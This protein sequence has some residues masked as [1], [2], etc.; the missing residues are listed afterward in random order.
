M[1]LLLHPTTAQELERFLE[2]PAHALGVFGEIGAGKSAVADRIASE[3]LKADVTIDHPAVRRLSGDDGIEAVRAIRNFLSLRMPGT[4][5]IRRVVII[6]DADRFGVD[7][8]NALLKTLEEPPADTVLVLTA[9]QQSHLLPTILSRLRPLRVLPLQKKQ[10]LALNGHENT[11]LE[12]AYGLSGGLAGL[13]L[14]LLESGS[15]HEMHQAVQIAKSF[16]GQTTF[17]RLCDV[18][19]FSKDKEQLNLLIHGLEVCLHAALKVSKPQSLRPLHDKLHL[20]SRARQQAEHSV[21]AKLLLTNLA[22][23]L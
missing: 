4:A 21:Q 19:R 23:H 17:E 3:L 1:Q 20:V 6:E 16:L 5:Q 10:C 13:F 12:R 9:A 22:T 14:A 8:Q 2:Q 18:E 7:A 15:E 11:D